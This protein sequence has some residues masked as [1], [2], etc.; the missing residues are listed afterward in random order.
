MPILPIVLV[1][2]S[3]FLHAGWNLLLRSQKSSYTFL[4]IA[5]VSAVLG[6]APVLIAEIWS[7]PFPLPVWGY[8][9]LAGVFQSTYFLGL[10][11]SYQRTDFTVAY[12][13]ARALPIL[14]VALVDTVR[15]QAPP[16][17][18]WLGMGLVSVGCLMAP[19]VSLRHFSLGPYR[20][21]GMLWI[22]VAAV[23]IV[24]YTTVDK[25]AAE[26]IEPGPLSAARYGVYEITLAIPVYWLILKG[27]GQPTG[28][29]G[30]RAGWF[31]ATVGAV[32]SFIAYWLV[33]WAY[34]LSPYASYVVALRQF[35]LIIGAIAGAIFLREPAPLLRFA[36]V[37]VIVLGISL[38]VLPS[39]A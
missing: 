10:I 24:G 22:L 2:I 35:S 14:M 18:A 3:T 39:A 37:V 4:R 19:M 27:L 28:L 23:S 6:L 16:S 38:V 12:P 8:L 13:L 34:Q 7:T 33:L 32:V 15:G 17:L 25:I 36:A 26:L 11:Y 5:V 30:D 9:C 29:K 1:L 20:N 31:W 21:R